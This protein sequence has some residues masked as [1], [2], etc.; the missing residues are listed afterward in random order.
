MTE[1]SNELL[2]RPRANAASAAYCG[3]GAVELCGFEERSTA[4]DTASSFVVFAPSS[5]H[6]AP[7]PQTYGAGSFSGLC[8]FDERSTDILTT[9]LFLLGS[10]LTVFNDTR[11]P[12]AF[13]RVYQT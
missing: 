11:A 10:L 12:P 6:T 9:E 5:A 4:I 7:V 1:S 2:H 13:L 3:C 8:G